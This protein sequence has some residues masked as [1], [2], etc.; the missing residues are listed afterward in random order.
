[1]RTW[2]IRTDSEKEASLGYWCTRGSR[3][4]TRTRSCTRPLARVSSSHSFV[5]MSFF[6]TNTGSNAGSTPGGG[7]FGNTQPA[8]VANAGL[9]GG[10]T[11][12][13]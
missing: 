12:G 11:L 10:A 1:M 4:G 6:G 13:G 5:T 2:R 9:F 7:L 8:G 3:V